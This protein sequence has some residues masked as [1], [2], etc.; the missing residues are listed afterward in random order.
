MKVRMV[1]VGC[2]LFLRFCN[3]VRTSW[4]ERRLIFAQ[5]Q[6]MSNRVTGRQR[7]AHQL[8]SFAACADAW[9]LPR[10]SLLH[11]ALALAAR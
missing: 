7:A 4:N 10:S 6:R 5:A 1:A 11:P 8:H 2:S 9:W 3:H